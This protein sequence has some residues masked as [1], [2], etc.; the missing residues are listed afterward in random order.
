MD[1]LVK[2]A[3]LKWPTVPACFDWLGLDARGDWYLRDA[4]AQGEGSFQLACG[5]SLPHAAKGNRL[6]HAGLIAFIARN[7]AADADGQWYFQNGPQRVYVELAATPWVWRI[8]AKGQTHSHTGLQAQP[9]DHCLVDQH[10]HVYLNT[11]LGLGLVHSQDVPLAAS[12][13]EAGVWTPQPVDADELP[14]LHGYVVSPAYQ[15]A[16]AK[17]NHPT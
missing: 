11:N 17:K 6:A 9:V 8:D 3:M 7:Y 5:S 4:S 16:Q 14:T 13:I 15:N 10:G 2:A 1:E 12:C